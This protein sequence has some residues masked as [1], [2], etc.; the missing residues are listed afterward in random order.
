[1]VVVT[2]KRCAACSRSDLILDW[3]RFGA[4][5]KIMDGNNKL[6]A[7]YLIFSRVLHDGFLKTVV[8]YKKTTTV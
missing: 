7:F 3:N 2:S 6:S 8:E 5:V 4:D 1:M